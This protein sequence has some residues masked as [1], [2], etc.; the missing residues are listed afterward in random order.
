VLVGPNGAGKTTLLHA[1]DFLKLAYTN[2]PSQAISTAGGLY[3][4][5]VDAPPQEVTTFSLTQ[6]NCTWDFDI[7]YGPGPFN[8]MVREKVSQ[9]S[10]VIISKRAE[11]SHFIYRG[12]VRPWSGTTALRSVA[13]IPEERDRLSITSAVNGFLVYGGF[14][15]ERLRQAGS[16]ASADMR[17]SPDGLN[18]FTVL[19]NWRDKREYRHA[20]EFVVEHVSS[21]FPGV[22]DEI[23][24][25]FLATINSISLVRSGRAVAIP[26]AFAPH[27][28]LAGLLHLMAV[29]GAP[30]GAVIA[31]DEFENSLHPYAVRRLVQAM[32]E[33]AVKRDLTVVLAGHSSA[34]LDAFGEDPSR[35][36]V[37]ELWEPGQPPT[38]R[39]LTDYRNPEW[40]KHFSLGELYRHEEFGGPKNGAPQ[41]PPA[42][43]VS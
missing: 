12:Q 41:S 2:T 18:A 33:C 23:E 31:I 37:M 16:Q 7:L 14:A 19:R 28:W 4:R 17:L 38:P 42:V 10:E 15:L 9:G 39:R 43:S 35:V 20:Y 40:L 25:E 22:A 34:L 5:N 36:F 27:G 13:D 24:F 8:V 1:L 6:G 26:V 3:I 30:A 29:G 32:R 11:E 21:A